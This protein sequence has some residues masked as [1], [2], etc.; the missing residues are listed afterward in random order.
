MKHDI[1][2]QAGADAR[3]ARQQR[4]RGGVDIDPDRIHAVLDHGVERARQL[5]LAEI[6]LVLADADRFR[7]D[8]DQLGEGILQPSR[9]RYC[10]AQGDVEVGQF[11]RG[12]GGGGIDRGTGLRNHDLRH[13]QVRQQLDQFGRELVGLPRCGSVADRDQFDLMLLGQLAE[14]GERLVPLPLRFM[15]I[16]HRGRDHL[17]GGVDHRDLDAGTVTRIKAHGGARAGGGGEQ[18]VAQI[19]GEHPD[20]FLL[21]R[22]PQPHP[23]IDA[24]MD[25]DLGAPGPARGVRSA[26]CRQDARDR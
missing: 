13:L 25:L 15:R 19:G 8:L 7:V 23:Q 21:G 24:E 17:A 16:D 11:L 9:N 6:V 3:D 26:I 5:V 1:L 20:R 4:R 22:I 14:D 12:I 10:A 18:E 2:C